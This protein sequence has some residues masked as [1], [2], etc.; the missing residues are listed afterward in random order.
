LFVVR[1]I[2]RLANHPSV[3]FQPA[4]R[5]TCL[6]TN[7]EYGQQHHDHPIREAALNGHHEILSSVNKMMVSA[8]RQE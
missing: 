3:N 4:A 7:D 2:H 6:H 5:S 1:Y 8:K